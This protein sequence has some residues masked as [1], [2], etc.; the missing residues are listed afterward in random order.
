MDQV[1][2]LQLVGLLLLLLITA[3]LGTVIVLWRKADRQNKRYKKMM[4]SMGGEEEGAGDDH[5][6]FFE[7]GPQD[8]DGW[9]F[10]D[11]F[12]ELQPEKPAKRR[13]QRS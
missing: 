13:R 2:L 7:N 8:R 9:Q 3:F 11:A 1:V 4:P 10:A 5:N 12:D 6:E